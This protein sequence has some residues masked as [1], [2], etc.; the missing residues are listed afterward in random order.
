[1]LLAG[2]SQRVVPAWGTRTDRIPLRVVLG[3][4]G[5]LLHCPARWL[6]EM[7]CHLTYKQDRHRLACVP[8][9]NRLKA[10]TAPLPSISEYDGVWR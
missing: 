1:M 8:Q 9:V 2:K 3:V 5:G 4:T 6:L 7:S 10:L